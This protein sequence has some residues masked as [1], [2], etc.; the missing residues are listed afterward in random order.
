MPP[1][2]AS[3]THSFEY[4]SN[5]LLAEWVWE[6]RLPEIKSFGSMKISQYKQCDTLPRYRLWTGMAIDPG[7]ANL[8]FAYFTPRKIVAGKLSADSVEVLYDL[9]HFLNVYAP[10]SLYLEGPA[11]AKGFHQ[12][13]LGEVRGVIKTWARR[14]LGATLE[15]VPPKTIRKNVLGYAPYHPAEIWSHLNPNAADAV[16]ILLN[17]VGYRWM[18]N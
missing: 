15:G 14:K 1:S 3:T 18:E 9:E 6:D 7:T 4:G 8:G 16:A 13:Q 2:K 10:R 12:A 17:G 11:H 5:K